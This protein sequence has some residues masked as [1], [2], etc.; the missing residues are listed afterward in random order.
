MVG[1]C[2]DAQLGRHC[3]RARAGM[4]A[5]YRI[6]MRRSASFIACSWLAL[7]SAGCGGPQD[8]HVCNG[9]PAPP[10]LSVYLGPAFHGAKVTTHGEC[11]Q[12]E[13]VELTSRNNELW[14]GQITSTDGNCTVT[15][16]T[17]DG[18][19]HEQRMANTEGCHGPQPQAAFF[20]VSF[21]Q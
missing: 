3:W 11:T 12:V 7:A 10:T 21:D 4:A 18:T 9:D 16:V 5:R 14:R 15:V 6:E 1:A 19:K 17:S 13:F 20:G 2:R 8:D